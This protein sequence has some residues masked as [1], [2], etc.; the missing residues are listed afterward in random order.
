MLFLS[1]DSWMV[2]KCPVGVGREYHLYWVENLVVEG[3]HTD[4]IVP[5]SRA[6]EELQNNQQV[7]QAAKTEVARVDLDW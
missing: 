2:V 6:T 5:K 4:A 7:D 3:H 1:T